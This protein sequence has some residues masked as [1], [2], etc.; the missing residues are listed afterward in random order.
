MQNSSRPV[1][2]RHALFSRFSLGRLARAMLAAGAFL[3]V[4]TSSAC[5]NLQ[6]S[7]GRCVGCFYDNCVVPVGST[8]IEVTKAAK[9]AAAPDLRASAMRY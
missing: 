1:S 4:I 2:L 8:S 7:P 9:E 5:A 6:K 3:F